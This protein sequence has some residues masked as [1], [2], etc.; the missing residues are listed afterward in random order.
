VRARGERTI[1]KGVRGN[2]TGYGGSRWARYRRWQQRLTLT[3]FA[4]FMAVVIL[5]TASLEAAI[6]PWLVPGS[7]VTWV[8]TMTVLLTAFM[9]WQRWD[10]LRNERE[11]E[12][13]S[14]SR[15]APPH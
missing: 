1:L 15:G 2:R 10:G 11:Q 8:L 4:L 12:N 9:V 3:Q 7:A 5:V 6:F 13:A 14:N